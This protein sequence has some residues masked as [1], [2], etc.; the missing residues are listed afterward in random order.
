[1]KTKV[2]AALTL[3]CLTGSVAAAP[4]KP[5]FCQSFKKVIALGAERPPFSS[6]NGPVVEYETRK[7]K[8]LLP[9]F[10]ACFTDGNGYDNPGY[11]CSVSGL[12]PAQAQAR[13]QQIKRDLESCLGRS[14]IQ[15]WDR[16]GQPWVIKFGSSSYPMAWTN[17]QRNGDVDVGY[18]AAYRQPR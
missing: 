10:K 7:A 13:M 17:V 5:D 15:D 18:V 4:A 6:V 11:Y 3:A 2:I 1:M 16:S 8:M 9:G 12:A 14:M